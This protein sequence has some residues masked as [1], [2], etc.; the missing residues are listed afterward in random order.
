MPGN[1]GG[2]VL[3]GGGEKVSKETPGE[4]LLAMGKSQ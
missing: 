3:K 4:L 2:K 1:N